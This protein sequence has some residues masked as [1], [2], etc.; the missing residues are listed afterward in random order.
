MAVNEIPLPPLCLPTFVFNKQDEHIRTIKHKKFYMHK[1]LYVHLVYTS[2]AEE[3][4]SIALK[5][6]AQSLAAELIWIYKSTVFKISTTVEPL[7]T[8]LIRSGSRF[9]SRKF[10]K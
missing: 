6:S 8:K 9:V 7:L 10:R 2:S 1:V 5:L 3:N 4:E